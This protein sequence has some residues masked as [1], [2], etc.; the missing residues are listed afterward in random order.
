MDLIKSQRLLVKIQAFLDNAPGNELSRLEKDLIKSYIQQL[1]EAVSEE[2]KPVVQ[3]TFKQPEVHVPKVQKFEPAPNPV[4]EIKEEVEKTVLTASPKPVVEVHESLV[5]KSPPE[6]VVVPDIPVMKPIVEVKETIVTPL[7]SSG[8]G[9]LS[10]EARKGLQQLFESSAQDDIR[11]G[12]V[13]IS[14]IES[15][16]GINDRIFTLNGLFGGDKAL[17]EAT[18]TALNDLRSFREATDL[19][20]NGP[21]G[22]FNWVD[23][24]KVKMAEHFIRI[25]SRRYPKA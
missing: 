16:L 15:A 7:Y 21:A 19:L 25:V 24:E 12:H 9:Q 3:E 14:N 22:Q 2:E 18:C 13:Q 6:P 4:V 11:F 23:P 17:F 1:Y 8:K 20:I 10:D 5:V